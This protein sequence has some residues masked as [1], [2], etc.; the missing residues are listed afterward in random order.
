MT[1]AATAKLLRELAERYWREGNYLTA[2]ALHA[3]AIVL[4]AGIRT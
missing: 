1:A 3:R 2:S 4:E